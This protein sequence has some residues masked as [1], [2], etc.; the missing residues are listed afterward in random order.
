M[1]LSSCTTLYKVFST[2]IL[3]LLLASCATK[4][5]I[6]ASLGYIQ[7]DLSTLTRWQVSGKIAFI[8][9]NERASAYMNWQNSEDQVA[10]NLNNLLGINLANLEITN[11][12]VVLEANS[13]RFTGES[14]S[15]LI[16]E[17]TGWRVPIEELQN[18]VKGYIPSNLNEINQPTIKYSENGL[19]ESV[20]FDCEFCDVWNIRYVGFQTANIGEQQYV[21]PKTID[22]TNPAYQARIK[23]NV[24]KW[25]QYIA[26]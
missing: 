7:Q 3:L 4:P 18:W 21:L 13:E 12:N 17:T 26:R 15:Q 5:P 1:N 20:N 24:S 22:M 2:F 23:I 14:P 6:T 10:F 19:A 8:T 9:P 16:Y 25:S 11:G